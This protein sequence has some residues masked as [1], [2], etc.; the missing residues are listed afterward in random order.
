MFF[1]IFL[2]V[3]IWDRYIYVFFFFP[4]FLPVRIW[5]AF[6]PLSTPLSTRTN[7]F[8]LLRS[9]DSLSLAPH[10]NVVKAVAIDD[11][12]LSTMPILLP[13]AECD[14]LA[15]LQRGDWRMSSKLW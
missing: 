3:H 13:K 11:G 9:C 1:F 2:P 7:A 8:F 14:F 5:D 12:Q 6:N 10:A 15:V 4:V